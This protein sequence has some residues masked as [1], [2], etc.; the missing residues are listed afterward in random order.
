[1]T[2]T[3]VDNWQKLID[4]QF[5]HLLEPAPRNP[6]YAEKIMSKMNAHDP[7]MG[8]V[9]VVILGATGSG[10]TGTLLSCLERTLDNHPDELCFLNECFDAPLQ[11]GKLPKERIHLMVEDNRVKFIDRVKKKECFPEYT[12]FNGFE[13]LYKKA[14]K[15]KANVVF[16]RS[17]KTVMEWV[18]WLR[19]YAFEFVHVFLDELSEISPSFSGGNDFK[20]IEKFSFVLKDCRKSLVDIYCTIQATSLC[21]F[22]VLSIV[23]ILIFMPGSK[24]YKHSRIQQK[25]LDALREDKVNGN[26]GIVE[27]FGK[28]CKVRFS[29]IYKPD[30]SRLMHVSLKEAENE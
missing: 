12:S 19:R 5:S 18:A 27:G 10:K 15:G 30:R 8:G 6:S 26:Q 1:M 28:F 13:D 23:Q 29:K 7:D 17:R 4:T 2:I 11:C 3:D 21:D 22:K 16:F 9:F 25:L 20:R 24:A 14:V